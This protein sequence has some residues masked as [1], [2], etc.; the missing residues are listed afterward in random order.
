VSESERGVP[1]HPRV[2]SGSGVLE[3]FIKVIDITASEGA[4]N[5]D[6]RRD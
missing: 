1:L 5:F 2:N 3:V 6:E 4:E